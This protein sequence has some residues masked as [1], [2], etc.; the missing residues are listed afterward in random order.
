MAQL[1]NFGLYQVGWFCCVLGAASGHPWLGTAAGAAMLLGHVALVPR[2]L[3]E[4]RLLLAAG[5]LGGLVDSLQSCAGLLD[6]RSGHVVA[7]LAPPWIVVIWMQFPTLFRFSLSFLLG[8]YVL[9]SMLAAVG[10]PLAF[11]VGARLG[12][13]EFSSPVGR[14]LIVL[15]LVWAGALPLLLWL[16]AR[17]TATGS[18]GVYRGLGVRTEDRS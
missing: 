5:L 6:F 15:G 17:W 1:V 4:L 18:P 3:E 16:A 13:V 8:R 9:G 2:P 10:G 12:A 11:W 14:S 7:C